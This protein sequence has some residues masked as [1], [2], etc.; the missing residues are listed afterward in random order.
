MAFDKKQDD[1][2]FFRKI[3]TNIDETGYEPR[4]PHLTFVQQLLIHIGLLAPLLAYAHMGFSQP[5]TA[6]NDDGPTEIATVVR[7]RP[8]TDWM[9]LARQIDDEKMPWSSI[10]AKPISQQRSW[11][12][13]LDNDVFV[14]GN[15][16]QDYTYGINL[17]QTSPEL[18]NAKV[19]LN[20]PLLALDNLFGLHTQVLSRE[21]R[22]SRE[23]GAFAFT[24]EDISISQAN[25]GDRPYASLIYF[26]SA[27]EQ[28]D[29]ST[30]SA[31]K[32][33]LTLGLLGTDLVG[34]V[35]N[36]IHKY[37]GSTPARGWENQISDGG[38][39]TARYQVAYQQ[40]LDTGRADFELKSTTQ[41]SAGYLT[42]ASWGL[43]FRKGTIN[44]PWSSFNPDLTSY[45]EK[46]SFDGS[47]GKVIEHYFW[48]GVA[49]KARAYNAFMEGQ[50]RDSVVTY[51]RNQLNSLLVEAWLGY[52]IG[53]GNGYRISYVLRGHTSEVREGD[54]KRDLLWGSLILARAI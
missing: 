29:W 1:Q 11:A 20:R 51:E 35:Q 19:T 41:V 45:G 47:T 18:V 44:S 13:A 22:Y 54:G 37:T 17:T 6:T 49:F 31:I 27:R 38:E 14:P 4:E 34:R 33:T 9:Q 24:P 10:H 2:S 5:L 52:T 39:L 26:S 32:T 48:G 25:A 50:F 28:I 43:S 46:A 30:N 16:D 40:Q 42:E 23:L 36:E 7:N 12:L 3:T 8:H 21:E 15:R 53:F